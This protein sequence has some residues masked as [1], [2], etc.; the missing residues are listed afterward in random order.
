MAG[1]TQYVVFPDGGSNIT[2]EL[3]SPCRKG[4]IHRTLPTP[5]DGDPSSIVLTGSRAAA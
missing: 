2:E 5:C 4:R 3:I 1:G